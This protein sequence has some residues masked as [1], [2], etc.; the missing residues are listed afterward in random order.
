MGHDSDYF[1]GECPCDDYP[2]KRAVAAQAKLEADEKLRGAV[3][4]VYYVHHG[5]WPY[6]DFVTAVIAAVKDNLSNLP[7]TA[8]SE[9]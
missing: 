8:P 9:D 7:I 5:T 4:Q 2:C 6:A 1:A 3:I